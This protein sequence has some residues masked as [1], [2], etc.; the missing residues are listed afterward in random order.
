MSGGGGDQKRGDASKWCKAGKD[1]RLERGEKR[2]LWKESGEAD[3]VVGR[4]REGRS[5]GKIDDE[6]WNRK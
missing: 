6:V 1:A 4:E 3:K 5:E 2:N